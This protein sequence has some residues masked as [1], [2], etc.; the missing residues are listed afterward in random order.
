M[1]NCKISIIIPTYNKASTILESIKS[2]LNQDYKLWEL[3]IVDDGSSDGTKDIIEPY[4]ND[5]RIR[6]HYQENQGVSVARNKGAQFSRC[7]YLIFLDSDDIIYPQLLS[8]LYD[9]KFYNYDIICWEV[10]RI[11]DGKHK[12]E[13]PVRLDGLYNNIKAIFLA[14]SICYNKSIF[15][16]VGGYDSRLTFSENYELGIRIS[17]IPNLNICIINRPLLKYE[18]ITSKRTSNSLKNR[19]ESNVYQY[20][21]HK[22]LF[23]KNKKSKANMKYLIGYVLEK[24]NRKSA[25]LKQYKDA[26]R[27]DPLNIKAFIKILIL[28]FS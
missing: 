24:S 21:K 10:L 18:V 20:K 7:D 2:V 28:K 19:F 8:T 26:W 1:E 25:A 22:K 17:H 16:K 11:T 15:N 13:R 12:I 9:Y 5:Q 27:T 23:D 6:Y 3:I 4:L 14:G